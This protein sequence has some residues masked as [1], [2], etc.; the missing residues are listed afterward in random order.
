MPA[1]LIGSIGVLAETSH[2]QRD[3]FNEAFREA[4][5]DWHWSEEAYREMLK[6]SGGRDRI[7]A[8][9]EDKGENVDADAL[10]RRK[11]EIF[12][13]KLKDGVE[14]RA[15]VRETLDQAR[16]HG[17]QTA[18][19][20]TTSAENVDAVLA[21]TGLSRDDFDLVTDRGD[22]IDPKPAPAVYTHALTQLVLADQ[23]AL[24]VEDNPGGLEAATAAGI[25]CIAFP[26]AFHD[27]AGF[28]GAVM[29]LDRLYLPQDMTAA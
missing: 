4:G 19:V 11:G 14:P 15:G 18:F 16:E 7:A 5:L 27:P 28:E 2:L 21:A 17:W 3:A 20:T 6:S 22:G 26:G 29:T 23:Q 25:K 8:Y 10:H 12:R 13:E 9:A 24:A 1:L